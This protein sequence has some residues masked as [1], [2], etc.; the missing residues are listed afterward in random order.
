MDSDLSLGKK[1]REARTSADYS[2]Q[3][4]SDLLKASGYEKAS[5]KTIYS[6][7]SGNSQPSPDYFLKLCQIY[8]VSDIL[9]TFGYAQQEE[10]AADNGE[11][12]PEENMFMALPHEMRQEVLR[13]MRYLAEQ[14][15]THE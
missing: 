11:L 15:G 9:G 2:V 7:E 4:V 10:P 5:P 8:G 13:Y 12:S 14:Q 1:L 3:Q 6:W